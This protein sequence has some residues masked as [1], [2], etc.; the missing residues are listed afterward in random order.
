MSLPMLEQLGGTLLVRPGRARPQNLVSTRA[1]WANRLTRGKPAAALAATLGSLYSLCGHAHRLCAGMAVAAANGQPEPVRQHAARGLQ[2][3]TLYEHVRRIGLDWP[4][5]LTGESARAQLGVQARQALQQCPLLGSRLTGAPLPESAEA[6]PWPC[7]QQWLQ[8]QVLGVSPAS[9]LSSWELD[10]AAWLQAW[11]EQTAGWLPA[12]LLDV[13]P[14]ADVPAPA[15]SPL[16][17]HAS[18]AGLMLLAS[19]LREQP[20]FT[21]QPCWQDQCAETGPW[22][23]LHQSNPEVFDTPWLR[24][25]ARLAELVRLAL[26]DEPARCGAQWLAQGS[27]ALGRGEALAWVEMARGLL[28]HRVQLEGSGDVARVAE[29]HVLAPTEWNFHPRGAVASA[30]ERLPAGATPE[31]RR[32]VQVLMSA[33]DPCV[34]HGLDWSGMPAVTVRDT[35]EMRHA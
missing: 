29:C 2:R 25:G 8:T 24:L 20:G 32:Q 1:D 34:K 7:L 17:V 21:R 11:S 4:L 14:F 19:S 3:E 30:L 6:Q 9:W 28:V 23:R 18:A 33:Y 16:R 31:L 5:Q 27:I 22:T 35:M 15:A 26:A 12:L 13:R 10:P